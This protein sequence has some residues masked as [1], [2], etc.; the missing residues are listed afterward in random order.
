ML[1]FARMEISAHDELL[2]GR[3]KN[4][5]PE[6]IRELVDYYGQPLYGMLYCIFGGN[7]NIP[8]FLLVQS[9]THVLKNIKLFEDKTPF[10]IH[11]LKWIYAEMQ[12]SMD[13]HTTK[14]E[15]PKDQVLASRYVMILETIAALALEEKLLVLL[16]DQLSL[17][18]NE[19]GMVLSI[20]EKN[21]RQ[22]LSEARLSFRNNLDQSQKRRKASPA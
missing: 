12:H 22:R 14:I 5:N 21:V 9:F 15:F 17:S 11:V 7:A 16:R 8:K 10:I 18:L 4:G 3:C 6:A 1:T 20:P 19:I 2:M 13:L